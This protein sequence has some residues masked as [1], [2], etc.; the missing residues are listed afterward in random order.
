[1]YLARGE[2]VNPEGGLHLF[3]DLRGETFAALA[4]LAF[5]M[6]GLTLFIEWWRRIAR[7]RAH[8]AQEWVEV[9]ALMREEG[10]RAGPARHAA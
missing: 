4:V 8:L 10:P 7:G 2:A 1:M 9:E 3:P 5:A 6:F